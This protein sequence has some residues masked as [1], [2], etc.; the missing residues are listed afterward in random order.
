ML[1]TKRFLQQDPEDFEA[2]L[3]EETETLISHWI[4]AECQKNFA[5]YS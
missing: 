1:T 2:A 5:S 4:S 3:N